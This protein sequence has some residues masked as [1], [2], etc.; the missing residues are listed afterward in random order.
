MHELQEIIGLND[1][2]H[3]LDYYEGVIIEEP[4]R[5]AEQTRTGGRTSII[6][7]TSQKM[8]DWRLSII[9]STLQHKGK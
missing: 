5:N 2:K 6:F 9:K 3:T 1:F 8:M 7:P 4:P